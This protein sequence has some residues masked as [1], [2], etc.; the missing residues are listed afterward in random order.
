MKIQ[1]M[2]IK[3]YEDVYSLWTNTPGVGIRSIDDS[4][5]GIEKFLDRNPATSFVAVDDNKIVGVIL[6]GHDGRR[7]YI[8]HTAVDIKYREQGIGTKLLEAVYAA[9]KGEGINK[10]ALIV[11]SN[12]GI[13]NSFWKSRGW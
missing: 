10:A 12:N 7:G 2:T 8:Y 6:C 13:G 3:D 9:L 11:F 4:K 5:P 1:V